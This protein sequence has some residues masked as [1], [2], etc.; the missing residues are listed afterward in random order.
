MHPYGSRRGCA[1]FA[2]YS[3]FALGVLDDL[4]FQL[5]SVRHEHDLEGLD[6]E[7]FLFCP[8]W[9]AQRSI[10]QNGKAN[11]RKTWGW[12]MKLPC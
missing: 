3:R 7:N 11:F 1:I 10:I 6:P 12:P 4:G 2:N 9:F 8:E 5:A